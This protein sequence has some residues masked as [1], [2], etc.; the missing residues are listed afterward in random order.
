MP[1]MFIIT[2]VALLHVA[3]LHPAEAELT[4]S[5]DDGERVPFQF[6]IMAMLVLMTLVAL[7]F[8][9]YKTF[10][11]MGAAFGALLGYVVVL[12]YLLQN[13]CAMRSQQDEESQYEE[14]A[15][16]GSSAFLAGRKTPN[17]EGTSQ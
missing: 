10:G 8:G 15:D 9:M 6:S 12:G 13:F 11:P 4:E 5:R 7:F 2:A 1:V 3:A 16:D 14:N 17:D